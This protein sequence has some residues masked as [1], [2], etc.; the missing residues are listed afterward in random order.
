MDIL[1]TLTLVAE[2]AGWPIIAVLSILGSGTALWVKNQRIETLKESNE[3]LKIQLSDAE[4]MSP[5][6]IV[7]RLA[8]QNKIFEDEFETL[9]ADYKVNEHRIKEIKKEKENIAIEMDNISKILYETSGYCKY[10]CAYCH[11]P[12]M[13]DGMAQIPIIRDGKNLLVQFHAKCPSC[14]HKTMSIQHNENHNNYRL[15]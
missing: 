6:A 13:P 7:E 2:W 8:A 11:L 3:W 9:Y 4:K 5:T 12:P 14:G 1:T 15:K 10:N